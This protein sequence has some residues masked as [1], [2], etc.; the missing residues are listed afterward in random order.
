M[1]LWIGAELDAD[2]ADSFRETR[3]R[4]ESAVNDVIASKDYDL[5][6]NGWDCIAIVRDDDSFAERVL[7]SSKTREMDFRLRID[8]SAFNAGSPRER[9]ALL[10]AMLWRSLALLAE[11]LPSAKRLPDLAAD[12]QTAEGNT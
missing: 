5:P 8:H 9:A 3:K 10:F 6:L 4:V 12:L 11:K 2:V 1:K 7:Y